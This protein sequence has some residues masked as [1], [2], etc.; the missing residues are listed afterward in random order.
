[1]KQNNGHFDATSYIEPPVATG[2]KATVVMQV[3][4]MVEVWETNCFND[5]TRQAREQ[6]RKRVVEGKGFVP[7]ASKAERIHNDVEVDEMKY[8]TIVEPGRRW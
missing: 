7:F 6:L 3:E 5:M 2:K 1:M 4:I 8:H